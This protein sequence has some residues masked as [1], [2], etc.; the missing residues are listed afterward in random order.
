MSNKYQFV[1]VEFDQAEQPSFEEK[2]GRN[3]V[4]FGKK[5][6]YSNYLISLYGESPKHGAII[7]GKLNYIYGKGFEDVP[8]A[9]NVKGESWNQ[10]M[11]RSILD[12]ELHGGFY[13]QVIWNTLVADV[14]AASTRRCKYSSPAPAS[15]KLSIN[16]QSSSNSA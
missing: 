3:Y 14:S 2:K 9:A 6:D 16:P 7:K 13:L 10:I 4:E 1:R 5:N 15:K 12:D 11:K 8:K